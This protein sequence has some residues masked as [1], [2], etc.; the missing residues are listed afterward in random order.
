MGDGLEGL[1]EEDG[2]TTPLMSEMTTQ[3]VRVGAAATYL[4]EESHPEQ[5]RYVFG[6]RIV[7]VNEGELPAQLI[8]RHWLII[9]ANGEKQVVDG[10]GVVGQTPRLAAGAGF[11]YASACSLRRAWGTME[12]SY[13]MR[14]DDGTEFEAAVGRFFLTVPKEAAVGTK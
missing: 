1:T 7:I 6:Y 4:E 11:K 9:D 3:G 10:P 5:Q 14:R 2:M 8:S 13:L 12:G